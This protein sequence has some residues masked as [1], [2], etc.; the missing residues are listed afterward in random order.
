VVT[1]PRSVEVVKGWPMEPGLCRG[2]AWHDRHRPTSHRFDYSV[3]YVWLDPDRPED[4]TDR[5]WAWSTGRFRPARFRRSDYGGQPTGSLVDEVRR[6]LVT[7]LGDRELGPVRMLT[8]A[9]R[10]GWLFNPITMYLAWEA[11]PEGSGSSGPGF[12]G[13]RAL[14]N[15]LPVGAVLEV[16]N[17]PWKERHRYALSLEPDGP[18]PD[19]R[20]TARF[21]K[22]LHVSPFLDQD[23][24]YDLAV[25]FA[26]ATL[27]VTIDVVD[28]RQADDGED[29]EVAGTGAILNTGLSVRYLPATSAELA[30]S[31][32]IDR[33]PTHRV[34]A[35]IHYQAARL[36]RKGVPFVSHPKRKAERGFS[37]S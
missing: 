13:S 32:M 10:W 17:T 5:H 20:L 4:L 7:V 15:R 18:E 11:D 14:V 35:G 29:T 21:D 36:W 28:G 19:A 30:R 24:H 34:S 9:R 12:G 23:Y 8:Q 26:D 6:D 33:L 31:L 22:K 37:Q 25:R 1:E 16:T 27:T 2:T 3:V